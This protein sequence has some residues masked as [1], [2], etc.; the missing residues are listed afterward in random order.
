[1]IIRRAEFHDIEKLVLM[2]KMQIKEE[3]QTINPLIDNELYSF[4]LKK[5]ETNELV[6]WVAVDDLGDIIATAAIMFMDFPPTFSNISGKRGYI[7]NM[8]TSNKYRGRG[9]AGL[10]LDKI[11]KEAIDRGV[12]HFVLHASDMGRKSYKKNGYKETLA[13]MEK[14]L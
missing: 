11:E 2:R 13:V 3:G 1:M 12:S 7:T 9:I 4:F 10:L 6:E 8:Y 14:I 5:M